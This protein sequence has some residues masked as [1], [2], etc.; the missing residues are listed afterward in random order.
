MSSDQ[1][2]VFGEQFM[3]SRLSSAQSGHFMTYAS[4]RFCTALA[5]LPSFCPL[6]GSDA[7]FCWTLRSVHAQMLGADWELR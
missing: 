2:C 7:T 4:H 6:P 1:A 5:A 3:L